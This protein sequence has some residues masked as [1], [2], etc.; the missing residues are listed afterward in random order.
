MDNRGQAMMEYVI[1]LVAFT[2][3]AAEG[4]RLFPSAISSFYVRVCLERSG[5]PGMLP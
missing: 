4:W 5:I 3:V 2:A 1:L